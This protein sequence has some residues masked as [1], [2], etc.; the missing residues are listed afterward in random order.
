MKPFRVGNSK[1]IKVTVTDKVTK[2]AVDI[3]GDKFY[4]TIKD[5]ASEDDSQA[6][7]QVSVVASGTEAQNG[8][9]VIKVAA[10]DTLAVEVGQYEY[11]I[12]WLKLTS[13]PGE[14]ETIEQGAV[15]FQRAVTHAQT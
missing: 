5:A 14:R 6:A 10:S 9:V 1:N 2:S 12:V 11:D 8:I 7:V 13:A 15:D 3:T 4:F